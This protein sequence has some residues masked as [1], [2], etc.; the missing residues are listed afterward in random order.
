MITSLRHHG[1]LL[2]DCSLPGETHGDG[3]YIGHANGIQVSRRR[4]LLVCSTRGWRGTD[5]NAS[6]I[7]QLR[8]GAYDGPMIKEGVLAKSIDDWDPLEDG[9]RYVKAHVHPIAFG[10]PKG[11]VIDGTTAYSENVFAVSWLRQARYVDPETGLMLNVRETNARLQASTEAVEWVQ[12]RVN[13]GEDDIEILQPPCL[14]RQ[15]GFG[16][17]YTFGDAQQT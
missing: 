13:E 6:I 1:M 8:D 15:K 9:R 7:F 10:V 3:R 12:F 5:D 11:A 14:L 17:G 16:T 4:F 2:H